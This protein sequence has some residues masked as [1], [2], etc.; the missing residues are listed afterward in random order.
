MWQ[1]KNLNLLWGPMPIKSIPYGTNI[2]CSL[3]DSSIQERNC[4]DAWFFS[5]HYV[6][7]SD[8]IQGVNFDHSYSPVDHAES[9]RI[10]IDIANMNRLTTIILNVSNTFQNKKVSNHERFC[11]I[12]PP[13]YLDWFEKYYPNVTI[14]I[15]DVQFFIQCMNGTQGT[16][17]MDYHWIGS[18]I[19]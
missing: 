4:S 19:Q 17:Q 16:N 13:Y 5:C 8:H 15:D 10:N 9:L 12:P 14:N 11:V 18:L 2:F 6:N 7:G 1:K 3:I